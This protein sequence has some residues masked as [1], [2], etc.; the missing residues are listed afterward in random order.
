VVDFSPPRLKCHGMRV[1]FVDERAPRLGDEAGLSSRISNSKIDESYAHARASQCAWRQ[2]PVLGASLSSTAQSPLSSVFERPLTTA[3]S[4]V[5]FRLGR[6]SYPVCE[7]RLRR[8]FTPPLEDVLGS[9]CGDRL[10]RDAVL[11]SCH[12]I[13]EAGLDGTKTSAHK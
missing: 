6:R 5:S 12:F 9:P 4:R 1:R 13:V 11:E 10:D 3:E 2:A 8:V 7:L